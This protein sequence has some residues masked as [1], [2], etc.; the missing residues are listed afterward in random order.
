MRVCVS[1]GEGERVRA[2]VR[3]CVCVCVCVCVRVRGRGWVVEVGERDG[4]VKNSDNIQPNNQHHHPLQ[5]KRVQKIIT[6][7][8]CCH[9]FMRMMNG[10]ACCFFSATCAAVKLKQNRS[11]EMGAACAGECVYGCVWM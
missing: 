8:L 5:Q 2:C 10:I 1:K 9:T 11:C 6:Q 4:I 7:H 3:A